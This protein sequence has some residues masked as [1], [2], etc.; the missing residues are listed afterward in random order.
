MRVT[1]HD[2]TVLPSLSRRARCVTTQW[3]SEGPRCVV[4]EMS[5]ED[6]FSNIEHALIASQE[7]DIFVLNTVNS[8]PSCL[9]ACICF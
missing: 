8:L 6:G 5:K 4:S 9:R 1:S 3:S 7:N 2:I